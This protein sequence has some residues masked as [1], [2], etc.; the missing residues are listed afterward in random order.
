MA[1]ML[2]LINGYGVNECSP[3]PSARQIDNEIQLYYSR[4]D[5]VKLR[6]DRRITNHH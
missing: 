3:C 4:T 1:A 2:L 6:L 5:Y